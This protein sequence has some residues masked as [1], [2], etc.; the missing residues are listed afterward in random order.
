MKKAIRKRLLKWGY[1]MLVLSC[2]IFY[3]A[4]DL[5]NPEEQIP[6]FLEVNNFEFIAKPE[7]GAN[8]AQITDAWVFVNDISLGVYEL[9][10]TIPV[11]D[12]GAQKVTVF[13]VIRENGIRSFPNIYSL[14]QRYE[15][16]I[17]FTPENTISIN[18]T[19]SFVNNAIFDLVEDFNTDNHQLKGENP[20]A[21]V[22]TDGIGNIQLQGNEFITF[23]SSEIFS[24][25]PTT[26]GIPVFLEFDYKTNVEL[27][28]GLVG[29]S[30]TVNATVY[31][32]ILCP[33]NRWNKV[34]VNLQEALQISQLPTYQLAFRAS[35]TDTGCG[36]VNS[37][38][39]EILIDNVKLIHLNN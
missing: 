29:I 27:E 20:D 10:T 4:C 25:L 19:T 22:A 8:S 12:L 35:I 21:V 38:N 37:S 14:Y 23:T 9:P 18:P 32:V 17:E 34:Y 1:G 2:C 24:D 28:I 33:I 11:L 26:G 16:T 13:P 7:Q 15:T 5:V 39:P 36:N 6:A 30:S 3:A 31:P